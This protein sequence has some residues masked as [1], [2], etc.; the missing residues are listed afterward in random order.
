MNQEP[1]AKLR[2]NE[3]IKHLYVTALKSEQLVTTAFT[4]EGRILRT[5]NDAHWLD[6][7]PERHDA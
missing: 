4:T 2:K 3:K 6:I 5:Y 1:F 7:T